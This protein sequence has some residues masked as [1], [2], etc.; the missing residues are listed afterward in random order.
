MCA[1]A[2]RPASE[3]D[4]AAL[5]ELERSCP[6][7]RRLKIYSEREDYFLRSRLYGNHHTL[8]AEDRGKARLF[9]VMAAALKDVRIGGGVHPAA[10]FYDLRVHPDYRRTVLG[11]HMLGVWLAMERWAQASG[12]HLIYGLVKHDNDPMIGM[13]DKRSAYRFVGR[14]EVCSRPVFRRLRL[15]RTPEEVHPGDPELT[16]AVR[17]HYGSQDFFPEVFREALLSPLM[18]SSG[19]FSY[20]R[21][22]QDDSWAALGVYR[23]SRVQGT[24]VVRI[25][26]EY[27]L[28]RPL[29]SALRP[30]VPLPRIPAE[31]EG[32]GYTCVFNHLA[33][34]PRGPRLWR[35]LLAHA[36]NLALDDGAALLTSAFDAADPYLPAFRRGA[37]NR[38]EYLLGVKP[39]VEGLPER[40]NGY[41]PDV[42]DMN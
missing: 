30:L 3:A 8:V 20:Y 41:Y 21:L 40:V 16:R 10:F 18:A 19:L 37:L 24:R 1:D 39:L 11:R 38:I 17:E 5:I 12:A 26:P 29:F 36:N 15:P 31:G 13:R 27:K 25:P 35:Q 22:R 6:Q 32:I 9:G 7:G 4:N 23:S 33:H 34:G 42:R 14:M 28:L 2:I